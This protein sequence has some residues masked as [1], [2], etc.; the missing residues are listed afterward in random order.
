MVDVCILHSRD[1]KC[2]PVAT[3]QISIQQILYFIAYSF[4]CQALPAPRSAI[5]LCYFRAVC[6]LQAPHVLRWGNILS[7]GPRLF[8]LFR[9]VSTT[10]RQK[11][12][13]MSC[14]GLIALVDIS[15]ENRYRVVRLLLGGVNFHTHGLGLTPEGQ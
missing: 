8:H 10:D 9:E 7:A 11:V 5:I 13:A 2:S 12:T 14:S 1:S 3:A 6:L 4:K 15:G